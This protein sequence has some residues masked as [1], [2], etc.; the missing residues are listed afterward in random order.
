MIADL[1][2]RDLL[3]QSVVPV[4]VSA[5]HAACP[6]CWWVVVKPHVVLLGLI[7]TV[8]KWKCMSLKCFHDKTLSAPSFAG[9]NEENICILNSS[10]LLM[11]L[12]GC[13][14][15]DSC[16]T[17]MNTAGTLVS[18][19]WFYKGQ[20]RWGLGCYNLNKPTGRELFIW[21]TFIPVTQ[22]V[23][24]QP[25]LMQMFNKECFWL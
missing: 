11:S 1:F 25:N 10:W 3:C 18:L 14:L 23:F 15:C 12:K 19:W 24:S 8:N 22:L 16:V 7:V 6:Y 20:H 9:R 4:L 2:P 13:G 21:L 5:H 17:Q